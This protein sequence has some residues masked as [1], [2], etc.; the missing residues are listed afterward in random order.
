[1]SPCCPGIRQ[2]QGVPA[3]LPS[4]VS[5]CP[6]KLKPRLTG[7]R[8]ARTAGAAPGTAQRLHPP[9]L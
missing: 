4:P 5:D 7:Q 8:R 2:R 9:V 6:V 1:M 3:L